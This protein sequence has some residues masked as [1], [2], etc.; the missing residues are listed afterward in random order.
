MVP[1]CRERLGQTAS[2]Q[3]PSQKLI[4]SSGDTRLPCPIVVLSSDDLEPRVAIAL[5]GNPKLCRCGGRRQMQ[6]LGVA[7]E[8]QQHADLPGLR[9]LGHLEDQTAI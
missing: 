2:W 4:P 1:I 8:I 7:T 6:K 5:L 9:F 3:W